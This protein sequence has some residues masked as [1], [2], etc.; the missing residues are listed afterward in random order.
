MLKAD[1][2]MSKVEKLDSENVGREALSLNRNE[3][4]LD[5]IVDNL[6]V[7]PPKTSFFEHSLYKDG[8]LLLQVRRHD[9]F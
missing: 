2:G 4:I 8:T 6:L 3:F 1:D 5:D 9:N 7:F